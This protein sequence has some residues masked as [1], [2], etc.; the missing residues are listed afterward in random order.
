MCLLHRGPEWDKSVLN[1]FVHSSLWF[2]M[3][4]PW[5]STVGFVAYTVIHLAMLECTRT[6]NNQLYHYGDRQCKCD[7][8]V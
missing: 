5:S 7:C 2:K 6:V 4:F 3:L 8:G 1:V